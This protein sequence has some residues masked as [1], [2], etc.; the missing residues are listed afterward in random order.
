MKS[1]FPDEMELLS[2]SVDETFRIGRIIGE[3]AAPGTVVALIGELGAGKTLLTQGMAAGLD[4][5]G[6]YYVTSPT[7][8]LINEYPGRIPLYHFDVYR[9]SGSVDLE[10]LGYEDYFFGDGLVAIEWAEKVMD[11]LPESTLFIRIKRLDED[12]RKISLSC[13]AD[14]TVLN[15]LKKALEE[16][17]CR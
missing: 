8:T 7:F 3:R 6:T 2:T 11:S 10:D 12:T 1:R 5:P 14:S 15:R 16:G 17:G 4:V 13:N 9:L